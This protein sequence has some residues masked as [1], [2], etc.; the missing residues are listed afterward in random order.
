MCFPSLGTARLKP[1]ARNCWRC[2]RRV[3]DPFH[4]AND[5]HPMSFRIGIVGVSGY[6]GGETLRLCATHP[7]IRNRLRRRRIVSGREAV[8]AISRASES[9]VNCAS[10]SGILSALPELDVLFASLPTGESR[11]H[12]AACRQHANR[13]HRRRSS[14][15]SKAGHT[16]WPTSGRTRFAAPRASPT[17]VAIPAASLTALAPLRCRRADRPAAAIII[18]AKSGVSGAGRGGGDSQVRLRGSERRRM[19]PTGCSSTRTCRR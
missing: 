13:R 18:D 16:A 19:P 6:G 1:V 17:R 7:R 8:R 14:L 11:D 15:T 3:D 12:W 4:F 9:W 10:K 2:V 5:S